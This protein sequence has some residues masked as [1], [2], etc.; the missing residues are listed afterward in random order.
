M[1][2]ITSRTYTSNSS[3]TAPAGVTSIMIGDA[4]GP[5]SMISVTPGTAYTIT[6]GGAS[7]LVPATFGS[8]YSVSNAYSPVGICI[9]WSEE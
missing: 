8:L 6:V 5:R 7:T 3:W 9:V 2:R 1:K 4:R